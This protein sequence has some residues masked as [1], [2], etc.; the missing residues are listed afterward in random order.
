MENW[1]GVIS[2]GFLLVELSE[3]DEGRVACVRWERE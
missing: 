3:L 2:A 1:G